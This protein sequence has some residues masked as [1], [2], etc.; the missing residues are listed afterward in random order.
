[1]D[2]PKTIEVPQKVTG[3]PVRHAPVWT[4]FL[5]YLALAIALRGPF[6]SLPVVNVDEAVWMTGAR[7]WHS[8]GSPYLDFVD[9]KPPVIFAFYRTVLWFTGGDS[10]LAL[11]LL[12]WASLVLLALAAVLLD[13]TVSRLLNRRRGAAVAGGLL[14]IGFSLGAERQTQFVSTELV[15]AILFAASVWLASRQG[16]LGAFLSG[17]VAILI[18][19]TRIPAAVLALPAAFLVLTSPSARPSRIAAF[20]SGALLGTGLITF[21]MHTA[22]GMREMIFWSYTANRLYV[23]VGPGTAESF[24]RFLKNMAGPVALTLPAWALA[25]AG[26]INLK[27]IHRWFSLTVLLSALLSLAGAAAGGRWLGHYH[28]QLIPP[29]ALAAG[30]AVEA[31][32]RLRTAAMLTALIG[33]A[34]FS[35]AGVWR[36]RIRETARE[37]LPAVQDATRFIREQTEPGSRLLVWGYGPDFYERSGRLPATRHL[38]PATTVTGYTFGGVKDLSKRI[39]LRSLI[40]TERW[41][42]FMADLK[43]HPPAMVVDFA[44]HDFH[45]FGDFQLPHYLELYHW[46]RTSCRKTDGPESTRGRFD[47]YTCG[48]VPESGGFCPR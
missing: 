24:A 16:P 25:A 4:R 47:F 42:Q 37:T 27:G 39:N 8:G 32:V 1:M 41:G 40:L 46:I 6:A 20:G 28:L 10:Q 29:L 18:P 13:R 3:K 7:V 21:W 38:T 30:L 23:N 9:T 48:G 17:I 19:F 36:L 26:A 5:L 22:E 11:P 35:A 31:P 45:Y 44:A 43:C 33:A 15:C 12:R 34:G 14:V 2:A